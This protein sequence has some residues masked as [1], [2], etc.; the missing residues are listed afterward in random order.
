MR[1]CARTYRAC[2]AVWVFAFPR[3][4]A[5]QWKDMVIVNEKREETVHAPYLYGDIYTGL[6]MTGCP[7]T[8][9]P[10]FTLELCR[11]ARA[12]KGIRG[13]ETQRER[14]LH[15]TATALKLLLST[16]VTRYTRNKYII[17]P[18]F[19]WPKGVTKLALSR[20]P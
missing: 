4:I 9:L 2:L 17:V 19:T 10:G 3:R 15:A 16:A 12:G 18:G 7:Y 20:L 14:C 5:D 6:L 13:Q 11:R 1:Q 8:R